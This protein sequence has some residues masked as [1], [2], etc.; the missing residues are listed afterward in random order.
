LH[1]QGGAAISTNSSEADNPVIELVAVTVTMTAVL[2]A[3]C[4]G[5]ENVAAEF[6]REGSRP[7]AA[8]VV[9]VG[10]GPKVVVHA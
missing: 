9:A 2:G 6:Q 5:D 1:W 7:S 8:G 10:A 4:V 3:G